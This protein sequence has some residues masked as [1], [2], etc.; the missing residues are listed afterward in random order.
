MHIR[1]AT[2]RYQVCEFCEIIIRC[3]NQ[4]LRVS[5]D[6][7]VRDDLTWLA[8]IIEFEFHALYCIANYFPQ[9]SS[10]KFGVTEKVSGLLF[11]NLQFYGLQITPDIQ[12]HLLTVIIRAGGRGRIVVFNRKWLRDFSRITPIQLERY[13]D[14]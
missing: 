11:D 12:N 14:S 5:I 1:D 2:L 8:R 13:R 7:L 6:R 3:I 4:K 10:C 9:V